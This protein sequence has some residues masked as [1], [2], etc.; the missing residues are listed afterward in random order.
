[1]TCCGVKIREPRN[2]DLRRTYIP[3]KGFSFVG[4]SAR[5]QV[6][7]FEGAP[8]PSLVEITMAA[9]PNGSVFSFDGDSLVLTIAKEDLENLPVNDP[10]SKPISFVYDIVLTD[11]NGFVSKFISGPF[12]L[13]EGVTR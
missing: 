13:I 9:S 8:G 11:Q 3:N 2:A 5:M 7:E 12:V 6:R 1:M 10:V 4:F